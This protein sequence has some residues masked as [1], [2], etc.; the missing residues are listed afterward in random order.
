MVRKHG[1]WSFACA[2]AAFAAIVVSCTE[3]RSAELRCYQAGRVARQ[4]NGILPDRPVMTA[5]TNGTTGKPATVQTRAQVSFDAEHLYFVVECAEPAMEGLLAKCRVD[6]NADYDG[7][8]TYIFYH[9][10]NDFYG[11]RYRQHNFVYPTADGLIDT[12]QWEGYREGIDDLRY[13]GTL[14]AAIADAKTK[15]GKR[16]GLAAEAE[17]LCQTLDVT[18]DL[19]DVRDRMIEWILKITD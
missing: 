18:G 9:G 10:W 1:R 6:D 11:K 5:F 8:M 13:L 4:P 16:A 2:M 14:R 15:G 3:A 19:Y 7:G 12:I 17:T